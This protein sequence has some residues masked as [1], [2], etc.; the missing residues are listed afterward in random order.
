MSF[1]NETDRAAKE[2]AYLRRMARKKEKEAQELSEQKRKE[3]RQWEEDCFFMREALKQAK[4]AAKLCEVP[5]GCVLVRDGKII[6][7]GYNRRNTEQSP[8]AHAEVTAIKRA[9]RILRD[10]RLSGC[11]LYVTLEPCP[12]CAGAIVQARLKRVVAACKNEKAGCAGTILNILS[13][14]G[15]NHRVAYTE[16]V[17]ME[18]GQKLLKD[19]FQTLRVNR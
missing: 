1:G 16:G 11:T 3:Q 6:S 8:L 14:P 19:F 4:K 12:M 5:I 9:S 17:L 15:F 18:E 2:A 10:W 13:T 7:R